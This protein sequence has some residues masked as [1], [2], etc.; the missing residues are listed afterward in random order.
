MYW[1]GLSN[2]QTRN[3]LKR[4]RYAIEYRS[5]T[6]NNPFLDLSSLDTILS[7]ARD[8]GQLGSPLPL[9]EGVVTSMVVYGSLWNGSASH[10]EDM[11][12]LS[13]NIH[14]GGKPKHWFVHPCSSYNGIDS[15]YRMVFH[16]LGY[17]NCL[18]PLRHKSDYFPERTLNYMKEVSDIKG[19]HIIQ[20]KG[21]AIVTFPRAIH[22]VLMVSCVLATNK[23]NRY[24]SRLVL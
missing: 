15:F 10:T 13:V 1:D 19:Y 2:L 6:E 12:T 23:T 21:D 17:V 11:D 4:S 3:I 16:G 8:A 9:L 22:S 20:Q 24:L 7:R 5:V 18:S 14:L